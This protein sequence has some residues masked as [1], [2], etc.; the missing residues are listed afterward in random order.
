MEKSKLEEKLGK[1][2]EYYS[3]T[4]YIDYYDDDITF[5]YL[6]QESQN[7]LVNLQLQSLQNGDIETAELCN[8]IL[9]EDSNFPRGVY[10]KEQSEELQSLEQENVKRII[11]EM[12]GLNENLSVEQ[13]EEN[14]N[15]VKL[16]QSGC[17]H[18]DSEL[19]EKLSEK[20]QEL[21]TE[22]VEQ[23]S[24]EL[25]ELNSEELTPDKIREVQL[26]TENVVELCNLVK[27]IKYLYLIFG[28][29]K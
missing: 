14:I 5:T 28:N 11:T 25:Q 1:E 17:D 8:R 7:D 13:L 4:Q 9:K 21:Q 18:I 22:L 29:K 27:K 16:Y 2:I 12:D 3:K 6:T 23:Y 24:K 15:L 10:G 20:S 26:R 19:K